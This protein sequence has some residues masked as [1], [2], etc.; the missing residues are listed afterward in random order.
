MAMELCFMVLYY[1]NAP[2][3]IRSEKLQYI[4]RYS[5]FEEVYMD[6]KE[7]SYEIIDYSGITNVKFYTS[8]DNG[9]Y[10]PSHWHRAVEILYMQE[11]ELDVTVESSSFT[12][13]P[14]DCILVNAN[15]IHSTKCV[16]PNKAIVLQIPL[17]FMEKY[18][19]D[20]QQFM[21][22]WDYQ[23]KDPVKKT[24]LD[25]LKTT[26]EQLKIIDDIRPDGLSFDLTA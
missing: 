17:D 6:K 1:H 14:G 16:V 3:W 15:V 9:S 12:I 21:F 18:V 23:T 7:I 22:I 24:K 13:Y 25:M 4:G 5:L 8:T 11:G 20:V 10:I 19:P 2:V 26:L